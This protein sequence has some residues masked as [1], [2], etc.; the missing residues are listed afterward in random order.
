MTASPTRSD[1][2]L[3]EFCQFGKRDLDKTSWAAPLVNNRLGDAFNL[4]LRHEQ[5]FFIEGEEVSDNVGC[6]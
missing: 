3:A 2:S 6:A 4:E 1:S 5:L